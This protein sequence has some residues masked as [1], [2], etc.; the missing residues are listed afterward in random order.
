MPRNVV[1]AL[2][3]LLWT[4][5]AVVAVAHAVLGDWMGPVVA[6]IV[7]TAVVVAWHM[8]QRRLKTT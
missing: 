6:G 2:G 5:F 3:V 4:S 1:I 7:V 8:R